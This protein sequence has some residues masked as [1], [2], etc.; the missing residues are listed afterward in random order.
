M[1][2]DADYVRSLVKCSLHQSGKANV[3]FAF[4]LET[5]S[6]PISARLCLGVNS[7]YFSLSAVSSPIPS[8]MCA[9]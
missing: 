6:A 8:S 2:G 7:Q 1:T 5:G 3:T 4:A 9:K